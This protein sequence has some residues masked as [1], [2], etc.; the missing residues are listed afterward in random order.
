MLTLNTHL[1]HFFSLETGEALTQRL[2]RTGRAE[3]PESAR[4]TLTCD[5]HR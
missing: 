1:L 4:I 3:P 2:P 5:P